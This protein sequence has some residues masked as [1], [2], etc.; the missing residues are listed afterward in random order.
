MESYQKQLESLESEEFEAME[1]L[2]LLNKEKQNQ[3]DS[4]QQAN[5]TLEEHPYVTEK[6]FVAAADTFIRCVDMHQFR[7]EKNNDQTLQFGMS[8][9]IHITFDRVQLQNRGEK[10]VLIQLLGSKEIEL[11]PL[12]ELVHGLKIVVRDKWDINEVTES[13]KKKLSICVC[14]RLDKQLVCSDY[15]RH[16]HVLESS[17]YDTA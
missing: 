12:A 16:C 9:G 3:L 4:I 11:G 10:A 14:V 17:H 8:G 1:K 6:E 15:S 5:R 13:L 7:L 2:A